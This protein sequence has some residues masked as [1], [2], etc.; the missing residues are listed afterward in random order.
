[1]KLYT[2]NSRGRGQL[3]CLAGVREVAGALDQ[4]GLQNK[5]G[6][7]GE[8]PVRRGLCALG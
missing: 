7:P 4:S 3:K 1:M 2:D 6:T 8:R 5:A